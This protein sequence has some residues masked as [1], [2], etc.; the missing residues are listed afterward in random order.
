MK[1]SEKNRAFYFRKTRFG[2]FKNV[3][4]RFSQN[5]FGKKNTFFRL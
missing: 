3:Q 1:K 2:H 4:N 5:R